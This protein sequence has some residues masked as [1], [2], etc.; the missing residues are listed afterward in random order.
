PGWREGDE[1]ADRAWYACSP[2]SEL[3]GINGL[4][5]GHPATDLINNAPPYC[6]HFLPVTLVASILARLVFNKKRLKQPLL[7]VVLSYL[8]TPWFF[9]YENGDSCRS[10]TCDIDCR[11]PWLGY[12]QR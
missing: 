12:T 1:Q 6:F 4:G 8:S 7:L 11:R 5:N 3:S 2:A 10:K 9:M